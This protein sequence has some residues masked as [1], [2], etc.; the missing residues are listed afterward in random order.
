MDPETA[1]EP[2]DSGH[3]ELTAAE[4]LLRLQD[5]DLSLEDT[6]AW[7]DWLR[8]SPKHA[9]AFAR[10]EEVSLAAQTLSERIPIPR[11]RHSGLI[12]RPGPKALLA[13]AASFL[14]VLTLAMTAARFTRNWW[15]VTPTLVLSTTVGEN[16]TFVLEDGSRLTLGG[17][18]QVKVRMSKRVRSLDL[19]RGEAYFVVAKNPNRP[20]RVDAGD[21]R[22]TAVG[23]QFDI[24]RESDREIVV[25]TEGR[26]LVEPMAHLVPVTIL[27]EFEPNLR[28]IRLPAGEQTTARSAGISTP[29][30]M[31]DAA[32]VTAWQSDRLIFELEPLRYVVQDVNRYSA[33]S[34][35]LADDGTG[36]L[37]ITGSLTMDNIPGWIESLERAFNLQ[38]VEDGEHILLRHR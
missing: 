25:V 28:P 2:P 13:T 17:S 31:S 12:P 4:W 34:I 14:V 33:R 27:R 9:E 36:N 37:L 35:V 16:R 26:V 7:Q 21:A 32:A 24:R 20:F 8:A 30:K 23:T 19:Q 29:T 15:S 10:I 11:P 22:I 3:L 5:P 18:S 38:A 6:L 1:R